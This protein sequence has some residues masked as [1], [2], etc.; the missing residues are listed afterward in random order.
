MRRRFPTPPLRST[1][2]KIWWKS[3]TGRWVSQVIWESIC[4]TKIPPKSRSMYG[5]I[6]TTTKIATNGV[7]LD[8][9]TM[10]RMKMASLVLDKT[11]PQQLKTNERNICNII[12]T[13]S[14][15]FCW[16]L[17][18]YNMQ[19][20]YNIFKPILLAL[21]CCCFAVEHCDFVLAHMESMSMAENEYSIFHLFVVRCAEESS[22]N[23]RSLS[24]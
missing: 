11:F 9:S 17:T 15:R 10:G 2:R 6:S 4:K 1:Q 23:A 21:R 8:F 18:K 3:G 14:N 5:S 22:E 24:E 12:I 20:Y 7:Q 19:H 16:R 13:Y